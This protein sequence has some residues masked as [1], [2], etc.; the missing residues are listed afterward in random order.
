M[1][2]S[3][4]ST[5]SL[6]PQMGACPACQGELIRMLGQEHVSAFQEAG[7]C[8]RALVA[9]E[10]ASDGV[11]GEEVRDY[12]RGYVAGH[13]RRCAAQ[14]LDSEGEAR[15]LLRMLLGTAVV[16]MVVEPHRA[17]TEPAEA[18]TTNGGGRES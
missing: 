12:A 8:L 2:M 15:A 16:V 7:P 6:M 4:P 13:A 3:D 18:G 11:R 1:I 10:A 9:I 17:T 5:E 14:G